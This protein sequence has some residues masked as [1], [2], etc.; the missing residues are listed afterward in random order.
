MTNIMKQ[1]TTCT[2]ILLT[3]AFSLSS[4]AQT[5][6]GTVK[7]DVT[8]ETLPFATV[9]V[10]STDKNSLE[11]VVASATT[12][13]SGKF[14]I[15]NIPTG[16][17]SIEARF[18]G[19]EPERIIEVLISGKKEVLLD[20]KLK[21]LLTQLE[22]VTIKPTLNKSR[23]LNSTAVAGAMLIS[24]EEAERFAGSYEDIGRVVKRY[25]GTTGSNDNAGISTHG[26]SPMS[27]MYRLEGVEIPAPLHFYGTGSHGTGEISA[28]N[29][30]LLAN[31]DYYTAAPPAEMG[32]TLGGVMDLK[33]R[34]GNQNTWENSI[35]F[36]T[37]GLALCSEG[38]IS[39]KYGS[40][41]I[42]SYRYGLSKIT[43]DLGLKVLEGDQADY[44]NLVFKLN[45]PLSNSS[46][47]SL[48]GVGFWDH[49][50][51]D[52]DNYD[53]KWES[54]YD[55]NDLKAKINTVISG[56]T[57]DIGFNNGWR[58]RSDL[59]VSQKDFKA[60]D[61]YVVYDKSGNVIN[62]LNYD[63]SNLGN[64]VP[65]IKADNSTLWL[66]ASIAVQKRFSPHYLLKFGSSVKSIDYKQTMRESSNIY[67]GD[68]LLLNKSNKAMQQIDAYATNNLRFLKWT[69]NT[70]LHL[71]GWTLF[72]D[73]TLQPRFS[74]EYKPKDNH[75][76]AF[77]YGMTT[78][79]ESYDTY[80]IEDMATG[81]NN[82][83]LK[84]MRSHQ[85][86]LNYKW[87]VSSSI[88]LSSEVWAEFQD[89]VPV[90][91]TSTYTSLNRTILSEYELLVN[92]GKGRNYGISIGAEHYMTNGLYWIANGSL[93]RSEYR[94]IDNIWR[95]TYYDRGWSVNVAG[96]KEWTIKN[97]HVFS[98]NIAASVMGG[99]R[100][101]PF[102]HATSAF[103]Y[104]TE[105]KPYVAYQD[106]LAMSKRHKT[107]IDLSLNV[108]YRIHGKKFDQIIGCDYV[109]IL[110]YK[111]PL[112]DYY[113]Y[114]KMKAQ[115]IMSCY[116]I[117]NFNYTILF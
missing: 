67:T 73:W 71:S 50:Y 32:N 60:E 85:F 112:Y 13:T 23:A 26:N 109:N 47:I 110:G 78:R 69:F 14:E 103:Y 3:I 42:I 104:N 20:F 54:L 115:T 1:I 93:F 87:Q 29:V 59:S 56:I 58:L 25:V 76:L 24:V 9:A 38:P 81:E 96:G 8:G 52:W 107:V 75:T 39:K 34:S 12:D 106:N 27:T 33:L 88:N 31:S 97:K 15:K 113:N 35:K 36:S 55:Q 89:E 116:S 101:T 90:S 44:H 66:T 43:N 16:R 61:R 74:M 5:L 82:R 98:V 22:G 100:R 63:V 7:N 19:Y 83:K 40:S 117:P 114:R 79:I 72:N 80:F 99:L 70:G 68:L 77:G 51:M 21:E 108:S 84:P 95:H 49:A 94:A 6:R 2:I 102:D 18:V 46:T 105:K 48:W 53:K 92:K 64:A 111:E 45:F 62:Y 91:P 10:I 30:S 65:Y 86:V 28:L 37:V 57:Y 11:N 17:Y 4:K 41:Y